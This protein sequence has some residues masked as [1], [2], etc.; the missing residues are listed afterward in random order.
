MTAKAR[1]LSAL[2]YPARTTRLRWAVA[3]TASAALSLIALTGSASGSPAATSGG[4]VDTDRPIVITDPVP[5]G[6]SSWNQVHAAQQRISA[7]TDQIHEAAGTSEGAGFGSIVSE[8]AAGRIQLFW[9]GALPA[10]VQDL[11]ARDTGVS[12]VVRR[13]AYSDIELQAEISRLMATQ[14][15]GLATNH[16]TGAAPLPDAGGLKVYVSGD[17]ASGRE[18]PNVRA[19]SVPVTVQGGVAPELAS[20]A[21][22]SAAYWGGANWTNGKGGCST[23]F[24]ISIGGVSKML[25]AGHCAANGIIARDGGGDFMGSVTQTTSP[26]LDALLINVSSAGRVFNG[27]PGSGEYTNPV[28]GRHFN[29]VGDF[30]CT[31]GAYSG[32]RCNILVLETGATE[33]FTLKDGTSVTYNRLALTEQQDDLNAGGHGDSGGPVYE[34]DADNFRVWA[35]GTITGMLNPGHSDCTGVPE[36]KDRS[37]SDMVWYTSVAQSLNTFGAQIVVG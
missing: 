22:D 7:V 28:A 26:K 2:H 3:V 25:S 33:T 21:N 29:N 27:G 36:S 5:A 35:K 13:A 14:P 24:A 17:A 32:T 8:P 18:L 10:R 4:P 19:A 34:V 37:C 31:S 16:V 1:T 11:L 30:V 23:G 20:R 9:K 15:A 6:F 12:A